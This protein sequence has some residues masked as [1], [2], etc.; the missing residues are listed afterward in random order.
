MANFR[1][2]G[3]ILEDLRQ[4]IREFAIQFVVGCLDQF[5]NGVHVDFLQPLLGDAQGIGL[6]CLAA[7]FDPAIDLGLLCRMHHHRGDRQDGWPNILV[8]S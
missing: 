8:L 6:G 5:G 3:I 4:L 7:G 1:G 2:A